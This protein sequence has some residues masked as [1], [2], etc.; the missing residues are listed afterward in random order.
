MDNYQPT[1]KGG[2]SLLFFYLR[3]LYITLCVTSQAF[4]SIQKK[5]MDGAVWWRLL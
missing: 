2:S 5:K 1:K 3:A 4:N